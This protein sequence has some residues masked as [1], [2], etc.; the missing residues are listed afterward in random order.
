MGMPVLNVEFKEKASSVP[1]RSERGVLLLI[2]RDTAPNT[3]PVTVFG[4]SDIP[5]SL[6]AANKNYI[7][8]ALIGNDSAPKKVI[9]YVIGAEDELTT[10][11]G[12][13]A[14]Q[15]IDWL[16]M[17]TAET[18]SVNATLKQW[19][20]AQKDY[21]N[22]IK[23]V[24]ANT[25]A[26][27][28]YIVNFTTE[29]VSVGS[30]TYTA[31]QFCPRI[32]GLICGTALSHSITSAIIPEATDCTRL[33]KTEMDAATDAGKLYVFFDGEKVKVSRGV[34]SLTT[35]GDKN[36][37]Q[38]KKIKIGEA[39]T[40]ITNDLRLL[41]QDNYIGK[42]VNNYSNRCLLLAA[43]QDY[44]DE[45]VMQGVASGYTAEFDI[46]AI[47]AAMKTAGIDFS[48]MTDD[49]IRKYDLGASVYLKIS[50][51]LLDAIEDIYISVEF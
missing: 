48:E 13:A 19:V 34:N 1:A 12:W 26:D 27:S 9:A 35:A 11:L 47:K 28:P 14:T 22:E 25:A 30:N 49:E 16:A 44:F 21:G 36:G 10:V 20:I 6:S 7:K 3:N 17:P 40:L 41:A 45:L 39:K 38:S 33:T 4:E 31:E 43:V 23:A 51:T 42:Y 37:K 5:A 18:D 15:K 32:A 50:T 24:L 46:E 2:L 29:S 8:M